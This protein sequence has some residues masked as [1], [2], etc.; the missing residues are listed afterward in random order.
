M[1][2]NL[3]LTG[4]PRAG[5]TLCCRL[6]GE[7]PDCVALFEPMDVR[8]LTADDRPGA[9]AAVE[10][11][12]AQQRASLLATGQARSRH[13]GGSVPDNPFG[14][15]RG[16][17]GVRVLQAVD[18]EISAGKRL[19]RGFTLVIKHNAAFTALLPEL[20]ERFETLAVVRNP[21]SVLASWNSVA[22]PVASGRLPAGE[23]LDPGLAAD[24]DAEP[25]LLR[26]QLRL[27]DWLFGR[28]RRH[29]PESRILRYEAVVESGGAALGQACGVD[30]V[31]RPLRPRNASPLYD[32]AGVASL[33]RAL[34]SD[35][36]AWRDFYREK[37]IAG[38]AAAMRGGE[39]G[40]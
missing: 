37:D 32:P 16:A 4:V 8:A 28:F 3:A 38:V 33:A 14:S 40:G 18:G 5:T 10:D 15:E 30:L 17:D 20:A 26:R 19:S 21:L 35:H 2:R 11:F 36:G 9:L 31:P 39:G 22:L 23:R 7:A 34:R 12:F 1:N 24:L 25:D 6:L 13:I 27:L 29:L